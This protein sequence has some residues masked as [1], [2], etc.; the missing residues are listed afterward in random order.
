MSFLNAEWRKLAL[1]NYVL[2]P[3]ILE[4]Y[5]PKKTELDIWEGKCYASLVGF[6]FLN[7]KLLGIKIPFHIN[8]EEVNLRFYVRYNDGK[9]WKRGVVFVREIVPKPAIS[10]VANTLYREHYATMPMRHSWNFGQESFRVNYE[11]KH[12][13]NWMNFALEASN[14]LTEIEKGSEAEFITEHYWGYTQHPSGKTVEYEVTHPRWQQYEVLNHQI[15]ADFG[16]LYGADFAFLNN[17]KPYS[18]M[19][20]EGSEITVEGRNLV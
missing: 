16:T 15:N 7:T 8:F 2:D 9:E 3:K 11:W 20:A 1:A 5:V 14:Q 10:F 12:K 18:V 13:G 6:M 17:E 4:P 19:L